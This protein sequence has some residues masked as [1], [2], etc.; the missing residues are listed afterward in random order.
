M[1]DGKEIYKDKPERYED[2]GPKHWERV[3][4]P[5]LSYDKWYK[6]AVKK[7][8]K[9][10]DTINRTDRYLIEAVAYSD[11]AMAVALAHVLGQK[12]IDI[13]GEIDE[14]LGPFRRGLLDLRERT[15]KVEKQAAAAEKRSSSIWTWIKDTMWPKVLKW[16]DSV[17]GSIQQA[18]QDAVDIAAEMINEAIRYVMDEIS[19]LA[20]KIRTWMEEFYKSILKLWDE[21]KAYMEDMV[22]DLIN[23]FLTF[24]D[25][26]LTKVKSMVDTIIEEITETIKEVQ[27]RFSIMIDNTVAF[28]EDMV[29]DYINP[30]IDFVDNLSSWVLNP[31][32]AIASLLLG[33]S[34]DDKM[35]VMLAKQMEAAQFKYFPEE[36]FDM[37]GLPSRW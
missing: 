26:V 37:P 24:K 22:N 27:Q 23:D 9:S 33:D 1:A 25:E 31:S 20:T 35:L 21:F 34:H 3:K 5:R 29:E 16:F 10:W 7:L 15:E 13:E 30:L 8:A 14:A 19:K 32:A 36:D 18:I 12:S 6:D 11:H 28:I 2:F 17:W 4:I